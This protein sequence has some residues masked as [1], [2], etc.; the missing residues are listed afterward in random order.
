MAAFDTSGSSGLSFNYLNG[1]VLTAM[2]AQETKLKNS[3]AGLQTSADG[4]VNP[5]DLLMVQ[6][7]VQQWTMMTDIQSTMAKQLADSMKG[8][9][10]KSS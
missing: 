8:V 10:Q 9:I 3:I 6:Q 2:Q 4:N 7:Q 1:T 5:M